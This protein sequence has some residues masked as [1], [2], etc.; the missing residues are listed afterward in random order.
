MARKLANAK[1]E[2][3]C[4]EYIVDLNAT[5]AAI[6][7]GY[8][9]KTAYSQGQRLLNFVEVKA[10]IDFLKSKR[11]EKTQWDSQRVL[12]EL[13]I[14]HK[15]DI[16]DIFKDDMSDFLP[17]SEWPVEWRR[18]LSA[19]DIKKIVDRGKD[20]GEEDIETFITKVKWPDKTRNLEL[21]GKHVQIGAWE[22]ETQGGASDL[23]DALKELAGAMPN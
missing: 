18:S 14:I 19:V 9:K 21:I 7:A 17:L 1:R 8:S 16:I 10:R 2:R 5:Q 11:S 4:Q 13:I 22:K 12:D 15:L 23:A 20:E 3:F 6:R